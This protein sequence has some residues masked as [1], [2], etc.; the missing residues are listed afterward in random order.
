MTLYTCPGRTHGA[1]APILKHPCGVAA[2]VLDRQD[3][4]TP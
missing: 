3:A 1:N 2:Q 4:H